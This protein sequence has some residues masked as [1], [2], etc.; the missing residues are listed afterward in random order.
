MSSQH[1]PTPDPQTS[2]YIAAATLVIGDCLSQIYSAMAAGRTAQRWQDQAYGAL[3]M[4]DASPAPMPEVAREIRTRH[5]A[6]L[7]D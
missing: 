4:L 2:A 3:R 7:Y 1:F 5:R 6:A